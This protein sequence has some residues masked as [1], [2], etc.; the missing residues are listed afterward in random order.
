[1]KIQAYFMEKYKNLDIL[2]TNSGRAALQAALE[3]MNLQNT[4][5]ILPSYICK[6][7]FST[8]LKQNNITPYFVD[9][10]E[11]SFNIALSS[12]KKAYNKNKNIKAVLIVHTFGQINK[13]T[14]KIVNFCKQKNL[15]LIED[16]AHILNLKLT[17]DAAVFSFNKITNIPIG[18]AYVKNKGKIKTKTEPYKINALDVYRILNKYK[19]GRLLIKLLKLFKAKKKIH[20]NPEKIQIL[21]IPNFIS[22]FEFKKQY[23]IIPKLVKKEEREKIFQKLIR[24]GKRAEKYWTPI[25]EP[26]RNPNAKEFSERIICMIK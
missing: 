22:L 13:D 20:V 25:F 2:F 12:I 26:E 9:C 17:G 5:I 16:C 1:M 10:P 18:G 21:G 4:G 3:D 24:K 14:E 7:V 11:N 23:Q 6:D 15:V 19:S 8:L